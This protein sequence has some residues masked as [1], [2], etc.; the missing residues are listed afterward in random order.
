MPKKTKKDI[1][2]EKAALAEAEAEV[3]TPEETVEEPTPEE[4]KAKGSP[5]VERPKDLGTFSGS[6]A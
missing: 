6:L 5:L 3:P 1:E 4:P 2:A